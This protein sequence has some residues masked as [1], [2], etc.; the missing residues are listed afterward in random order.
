M[1]KLL[2]TILLLISSIFASDLFKSENELVANGKGVMFIF[3]SNTCSYCDLLKKDFKENK[4]MNELAK[5]FN[6]YLINREREVDYLVGEK[7]KKETTTTLRMA[8]AAKSTPNI[9]I[10]DKHW[11]RIF[12][13]PGY[14]HPAQ[15]ITFMKFVKGLHDGRYNTTEWKKFLKDNGVS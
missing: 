11:N 12:Q 9:V 6:I 14:A 3:E 4:E 15:M 1:M 7:K 13:V 8:F 10:F 5:E 2:F